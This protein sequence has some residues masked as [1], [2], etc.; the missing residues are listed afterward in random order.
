[1]NGHFSLVHFYFHFKTDQNTFGLHSILK[2]IL[3]HLIVDLL[4]LVTFFFLIMN[5]DGLILKWTIILEYKY[6]QNKLKMFS[7][8][9]ENIVWI[10]FGKT[11]FKIHA[12]QNNQIWCGK[13]D[14]FQTRV[15]QIRLNRSTKW[16]LSEMTYSSVGV[17]S[18]WWGLR[19]WKKQKCLNSNLI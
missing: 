2:S 10:L 15:S 1:M 16:T 18:H 4:K 14:C 12:F 13:M 5:M 11:N 6:S 17:V 7:K 3:D 19:I 8:W 9:V